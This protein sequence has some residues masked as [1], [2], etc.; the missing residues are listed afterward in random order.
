MRFLQYRIYGKDDPQANHW[1][2]FNV[3][4]ISQHYATDDELKVTIHEK[5]LTRFCTK[6][7]SKITIAEIRKHTCLGY[8]RLTKLIPVKSKVETLNRVK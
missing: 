2:E 5:Y 7:K 1:I 6:C 4:S 8:Q 3:S